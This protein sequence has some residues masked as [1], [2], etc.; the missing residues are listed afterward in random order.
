MRWRL[1]WQ[2]CDILSPV[3]PEKNLKRSI[4]T[5]HIEGQKLPQYLV[6]GNSN[7]PPVSGCHGGVQDHD[8]IDQQLRA[9]IVQVGED[10][11]FESPH[12]GVAVAMARGSL[13]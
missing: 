9:G 10:A 8:R 2:R 5:C 13:A 1:A 11:L 6:V 4:S 7:I 12:R 3:T